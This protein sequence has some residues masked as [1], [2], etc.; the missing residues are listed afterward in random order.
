[1][2]QGDSYITSRLLYKCDK[3]IATIYAEAIKLATGTQAN[4]EELLK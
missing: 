4:K 3:N 2:D 1:M